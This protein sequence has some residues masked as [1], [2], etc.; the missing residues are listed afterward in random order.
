MEIINKGEGIG[1][2]NEGLIWNEEFGEVVTLLWALSKTS[3]GS[4]AATTPPPHLE[5]RFMD[6]LVTCRECTQLS[7]FS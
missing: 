6:F 5:D 2:W 1:E 4:G 3:W 7:R